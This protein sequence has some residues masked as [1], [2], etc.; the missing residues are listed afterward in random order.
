EAATGKKHRF[1]VKIPKKELRLKLISLAGEPFANEPYEIDVE[2]EVKEGTTDGDG[3]VKEKVPA[4]AQA[5]T[6]SLGDYV[7][8][9]RFG[10]LNPL[11]D[12]DKN[13]ASGIQAR[14]KN[15]GYDV[16]PSDGQLGPR[17]KAALALF[18]SDHRLSVNGE[19]NEDTLKKLEK[20]YGS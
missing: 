4:D 15:L 1:Q 3:F 17:T 6:L 19:P 20:E 9:L 10:E 14:L 5:A 2:G 18:Q 13:D 8:E 12:R 11:R 7:V 16:G